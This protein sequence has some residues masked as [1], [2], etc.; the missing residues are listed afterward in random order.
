MENEYNYSITELTHTLP[1]LQGPNSLSCSSQWYFE[2]S[3]SLSVLNP[4]HKL[5][6]DVADYLLKPTLPTT[7]SSY[8]ELKNK[9]YSAWAHQTRWRQPLKTQHIHRMC[10][11]PMKRH[12][13][14]NVTGSLQK[15]TVCSFASFY[16][17]F[18]MGLSTAFHHH[19]CP[20]V[21]V[22]CTQLHPY[23]Q[24]GHYFENI[25]SC[26]LKTFCFFEQDFLFLL[27]CHPRQHSHT[28]KLHL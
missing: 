20:L 25:V 26:S 9:E 15:F 1:V 14:R 10:V 23:F 2:S 6:S 24:T 16:E 5:C 18:W 11:M 17:G 28:Q 21:Q 7:S 8:D 3:L 12:V 27:C 22:L 19:M 13:P 4:C